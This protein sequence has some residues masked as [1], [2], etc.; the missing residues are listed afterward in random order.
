MPG[1]IGMIQQ[2]KEGCFMPV[3]ELTAILLTGGM[4]VLSFQLSAQQ[5]TG[6]IAGAIFDQSGATIQNAKVTLRNSGT[7]QTRV[8]QS[9]N[10]GEYVF[11]PLQVGKYELTASAA[12][13]QTEVRQNLELQGQQRLDVNFTLQVGTE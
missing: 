11:T 12:G 1:M 8:T 5:D 9:G 3:R 6:T 7:G 4:L 2:Q 13:F 10:S